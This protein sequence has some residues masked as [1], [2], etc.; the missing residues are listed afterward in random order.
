MSLALWIACGVAVLA[1][2]AWRLRVAGA[3]LRGIL[4]EDAAPAPEAAEP[5]IAWPHPPRRLWV[6][7]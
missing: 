5:A 4:A 1:L 6:D 3:V 7:R 2:L